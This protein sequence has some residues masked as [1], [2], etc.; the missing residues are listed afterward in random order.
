MK[1]LR[2][3]TELAL[4]SERVLDVGGWYR[5]LNAATHVLD[6]NGYE[7]RRKAAALDPEQPE[8]FDSTTWV[9]LDICDREPWPYPD[10]YFDFSVCSH[11][12][13]DIR[14]PFGSYRNSLESAEAAILKPPASQR[15]S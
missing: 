2:R 8:R 10:K 3:V 1:G 4:K 5:P 9:C 15:K 14:D 11:T 7:T 12:L 6:I 13:E